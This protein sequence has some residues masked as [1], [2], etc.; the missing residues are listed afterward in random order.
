MASWSVSCV[1]VGEHSIVF[2][3]VCVCV[4]VW[5]S[6]CACLKRKLWAANGACSCCCV[7]HFSFQSAASYV[8]YGCVNGLKLVGN[9]PLPP[10]PN[11]SLGSRQQ[12]VV[13]YQNHLV[14][15]WDVVPPSCC[16]LPASLPYPRGLL[17]G[18]WTEQNVSITLSARKTWTPHH[19]L[20][21][22][23]SGEWFLMRRLQPVFTPLSITTWRV[24]W[25]AYLVSCH[26]GS[27]HAMT[28]R[29]SISGWLSSRVYCLHGGSLMG[30]F[31][32]DGAGWNR[33]L[34]E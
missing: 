14:M 28:L 3:R 6:V 31:E 2:E 30:L 27:Y 23:V 33:S 11:P 19:Q 12:L 32:L 18:V 16:R 34:P 1:S 29:T 13:V 25:W 26:S 9:S 15:C 21:L 7:S 8:A 24:L 20:L 4:C 22:L 10:T 5:W 17:A